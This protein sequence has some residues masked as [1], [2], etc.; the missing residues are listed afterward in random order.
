MELEKT[1]E[2]LHCIGNTITRAK[3]P[4]TICQKANGE[5]VQAGIRLRLGLRG[6][7]R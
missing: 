3:R 5:V 4:S 2:R 6:E 7:N 1:S